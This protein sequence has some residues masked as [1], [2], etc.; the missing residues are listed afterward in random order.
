MDWD[1]FGVAKFLKKEGD[2]AFNAD[3]MDKAKECYEMA[4]HHVHSDDSEEAVKLM[5][6]LR[7]NMSKVLCIEKNY[8]GAIESATMVI[9]KNENDVK[10]LYRRA[11]AYFQSRMLIEAFRDLNKAHALD[12][13]DKDVN[14]FRKRV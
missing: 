10:A 2:K 7:L 5:R 12:G 3:D 13:K 14:K 11:T 1:L 9:D 6:A 4:F 8:V